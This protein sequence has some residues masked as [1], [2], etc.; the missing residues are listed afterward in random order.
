MISL[1]AFFGECQFKECRDLFVVDGMAG[2]GQVVL[3]IEEP[4]AEQHEVGI[5]LVEDFSD[6]LD[7]V[8]TLA[9]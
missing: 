6:G 5:L 7:T 8:L 9:G 2:F 1:K 3:I 4:L